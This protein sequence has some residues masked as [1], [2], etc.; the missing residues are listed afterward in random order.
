MSMLVNPLEYAGRITGPYQLAAFGIA[1]LLYASRFAL[2]SKNQRFALKLIAAVSTLIGIAALAGDLILKSEGIFHIRIVVLSPEEQPVDQADL[3]SSVGGELKKAGGNW[4]FDLPPQSK[5]SSGQITFYAS[6][7]DAYLAGN[8]TL[9]L[10]EDYFPTVTVQLQRLPEVPIRG[11][12]IDESGKSMAGARVSVS[13]FPDIAI[14]DEV[15][16]FSIPS[17][18]AEGQMVS[19]H[20]EK[21]DRGA[22]Q[23]AKAGSDA[24]LVIRKR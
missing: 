24:E 15:G 6:V 2:K 19:I 3:S 23:L 13:G 1:I 4:E 20:A 17:H 18:H 11:R 9:A 22:D 14:T 21:G 7:K 16:N 8:S 5:P 12:V 10:K